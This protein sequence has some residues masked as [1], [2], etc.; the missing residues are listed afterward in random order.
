M[1]DQLT[2]TPRW[3]LRKYLNDSDFRYDQPYQLA[4][5]HGNLM[6]TE[7]LNDLVLLLTGGGGTVFDQTNS[8]LGVGDSNAAED[9]AQTALQAASNKLYKQCAASYPA[10]TNGSGGDAGKK[11]VTWR[12]VFTGLEANFAWNEF[13]L[14]NG[15]GGDSAINLNRKVSAQGTKV[16]GQTWTLDLSIT[17][18]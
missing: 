16:S 12:A 2:M 10:I 6:L 8:Y 7:G 17:F 5:I 4:I 9:R 13:T 15:S 18:G 1:N 14:A 11:I 3:V